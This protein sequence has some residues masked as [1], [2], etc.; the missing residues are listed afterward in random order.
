MIIIAHRGLVF[1]PNQSRE[2]LPLQIL[3]A[4]QCGFHAEIDIR[5]IN[6]QWWLGH[7]EPQYLIDWEFLRRHRHR[8][9][10]H[11]KDIPTMQ[12]L[13][14]MQHNSWINQITNHW[15]MHYFSHDQDELSLTSHGYLWHYPGKEPL[16]NRSIAV[17][18]ERAPKWQGLEHCY[19]ICTDYAMDCTYRFGTRPA[20]ILIRQAEALVQ[21]EAREV[22]QHAYDRLDYD[23]VRYRD[24]IKR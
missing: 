9:I 15:S 11:A 20:D 23:V 6:G 1:G 12:K 24:E 22:Y 19:G 2:N 16:G 10:L 4:I 5:F 14:G 18:P 13:N 17:M 8:L 21:K 7:D 3:Q